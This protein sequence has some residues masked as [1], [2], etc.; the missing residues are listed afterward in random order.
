MRTLGVVLSLP[1]ADPRPRQQQ[2]PKPVHI[3]TFVAK[4]AVEAFDIVVLYRLAGL[5]STPQLRKYREV[6]SQID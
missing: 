2:V 4:F 3:Q 5:E 6:S 1:R